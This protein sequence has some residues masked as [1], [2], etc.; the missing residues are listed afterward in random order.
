MLDCLNKLLKFDSTN[1]KMSSV[2]KWYADG[3]KR[4]NEC[5]LYPKLWE[6]HIGMVTNIACEHNGNPFCQW[7]SDSET[8]NPDIW[9]SHKK[10]CENV[11]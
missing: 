10:E 6:S 11:Y 5:P 8:Y 9:Q 7:H 2:V 1:I 3:T 4:C